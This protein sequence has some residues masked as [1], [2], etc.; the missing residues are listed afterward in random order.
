MLQ[1][2]ATLKAKAA[3]LEKE[4]FHHCHFAASQAGSRTFGLSEFLEDLFD[5]VSKVE[6]EDGPPSK[7]SQPED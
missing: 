2:S 5:E 3:Q 6:E 1:L 7:K 4:A